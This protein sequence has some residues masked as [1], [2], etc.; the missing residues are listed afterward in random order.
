MLKTV[1]IGFLILVIVGLLIDG[2]L[3]AQAPQRD[4][5]K[6]NATTT[7]PS[8]QAQRPTLPPRPVPQPL[9][10]PVV[11]TTPAPPANALPSFFTAGRTY[12]FQPVVGDGF[13]ARVIMV[14]AAGWVQIQ[15]Q[16]AGSDIGPVAEWYNLDNIVA[17]K[18]QQ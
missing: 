14:D 16:P 2:P 15:R 13:V 3:R 17:M 5:D 1:A 8:A 10:P 6:S 4:K 7:Q 11:V 12:A 18:G 9:P